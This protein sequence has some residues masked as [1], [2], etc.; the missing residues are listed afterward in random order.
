[1]DSLLLDTNI[2][3]YI[4]K[5]DTRAELYER[6]LQGKL[7][8]MSA[9]TLAELYRWPFMRG[10]GIRAISSL[11]TR[12]RTYVLVRYDDATCWRWAQVVSAKGRPMSYHDAWVA[13]TALR[14]GAPLVTHN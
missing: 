4:I 6:Y 3:S 9:A 5:A 14:H 8:C 7:L 11:K 12:L 2:I 1:M 13:A 10:W